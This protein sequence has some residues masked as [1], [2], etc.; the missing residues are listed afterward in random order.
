MNKSKNVDMKM[1]THGIIHLIIDRS[2]ACNR[3]VGRHIEGVVS[4]YPMFVT[5]KNCRRRMK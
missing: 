5:C 1:S 3:A 4:L 2:Y